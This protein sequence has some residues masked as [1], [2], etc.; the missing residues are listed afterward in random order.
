MATHAITIGTPQTGTGSLSIPMPAGSLVGTLLL[1]YAGH[2]NFAGAVLSAAPDGS[3]VEMAFTQ[4]ST[5]KNS[6]LWGKI[7]TA[8][9]STQAVTFAGTAGRL[10]W[11]LA[12]TSST[13]WPVIDQVS[14]GYTGSNSGSSLNLR[15]GAR[16]ISTI[17]NLLLQLG[18]R[19]TIA[20]T[21]AS[22][23]PTSTWTAA[24][25]AN[26]SSGAGNNTVGAGQIYLPTSSSSIAENSVTITD[27]TDS[28]AT[29]GITIELRPASQVLPAKPYIGKRLNL[30]RM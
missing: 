18:S 25:F 14:A 17:G 5:N 22:I 1:I 29:R 4:P 20:C 2:R 19:A 10:G 27:N 13:G 11:S 24:G 21:A 3:W 26:Q 28:G 15:F 8:S 23:T 6:Y 16:T 9:E 12:I 30:Q 7:G